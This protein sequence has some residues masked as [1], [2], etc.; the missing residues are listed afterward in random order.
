MRDFRERARICSQ[1]L[2]D[3]PAIDEVPFASAGDQSGLAQN[4]EMVGDRRGRY[5]A[6]RNNLAASHVLGRR[7]GL[8]NSEPGLV[9]QGFRYFFDMGT[10]H[11]SS[12]FQRNHCFRNAANPIA[13]KEI[14]EIP[15]SYHFDDHQTNE[16]R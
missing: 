10:V 2:G 15:A 16:I 1:G 9:R 3:S 13:P 6:H 7:N 14:P 8:K 4:L 12:R 5:A 11:E